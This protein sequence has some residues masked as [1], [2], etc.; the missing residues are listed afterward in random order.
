MKKKLF[1]VVALLIVVG[2]VCGARKLLTP[3]PKKVAEVH[4]QS[5]RQEGDPHARVKVVEFIDFQ[6]PACATGMKML[7]TYFEK[8]P[9]DIFIQVKYFPL[10]NM[11][12]HAMVSA[13]YSECSSRQNKFWELDALILDQQKQWE[14]L[15]NPE[16]VFQSMAQ[17]VGM[18]MAQLNACV[19]SDDARLV[20]NEEK[21]AGQTLGIK[22]TPTYF[23][24]NQM[25]VG[26]KSMEE[27]MKRLFPTK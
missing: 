14:L 18:N 1:T 2:V 25:V 19:A 26:T 11:H 15:I 8:Y 16:P 24:N 23:I 7:R 4:V 17:Q 27:V 22:S 3:K 9:H 21:A 20:I 13:L 5:A 10:T 6:C 12:R